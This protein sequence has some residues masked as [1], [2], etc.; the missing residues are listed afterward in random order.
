MDLKQPAAV[1][2]VY[3]A[4]N[5]ITDYG[6]NCGIHDWRTFSHQVATALVG[7]MGLARHYFLQE[8]FDG[9][10]LNLVHL[11]AVDADNATIL[12]AKLTEPYAE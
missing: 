8:R 9:K 5:L 6:M 4:Y 12:V 7:D 2:D 1:I 3:D 11:L 10:L